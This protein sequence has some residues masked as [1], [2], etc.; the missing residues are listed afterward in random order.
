MTVELEFPPASTL[1]K[2]AQSHYQ[3]RSKLIDHMN[4][5]A[6]Q[7][8]RSVSLKDFPTNSIVSM[9]PELEKAGYTLTVK[10]TSNYFSNIEVSW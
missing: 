2:L 10:T 8:Y 6:L 9:K 1:V 4:E 7:G 3:M 5:A